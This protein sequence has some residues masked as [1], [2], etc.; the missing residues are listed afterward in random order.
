MLVNFENV[1]GKNYRRFSSI[2]KNESAV[3]IHTYGNIIENVVLD[4]KLSNLINEHSQQ[5][6]WNLFNDFP[7]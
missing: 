5:H 6:V 3:F 2:A 4:K 1:Y 7:P